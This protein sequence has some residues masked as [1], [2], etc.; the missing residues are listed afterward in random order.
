MVIEKHIPQGGFVR[1]TLWLVN[2]KYS[3]D[4]LFRQTSPSCC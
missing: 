1:T 3:D 2:A 4:N